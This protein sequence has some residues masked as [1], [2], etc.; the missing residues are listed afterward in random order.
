[1]DNPLDDMDDEFEAPMIGILRNKE[2]VPV[3]IEDL[4]ISFEISNRCVKQT[5]IGKI[6][7][8]TV[9]LGI[10]YGTYRPKWFETTIFGGDADGMQVRYETW[11]EAVRGHKEVCDMIRKSRK[12]SHKEIFSVD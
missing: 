10:N 5:T 9:F 4:A 1:M 11:D 7:I 12:L 3:A 2:V 6:R 8:S